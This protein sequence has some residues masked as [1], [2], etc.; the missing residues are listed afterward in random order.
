MQ[1]GP[2]MLNLSN[3]VG[4]GTNMQADW[5][6]VLQGDSIEEV[7]GHAET[8]SQELPDWIERKLAERGIKRNVVVRR[9]RLNQ[10]YAYQIMAGLRRA[11]RDKLVQLCFG[12]GLSVD[13][14]CEL[15][16]VGSVNRL[17]PTCRRDIIIAY[18]LDHGLDVTE[19]DDLLWRY[20]ESTLVSEDA[21]AHK[22]PA[23]GRDN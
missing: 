4:R 12:M 22:N 3:N 8:S 16:E 17:N 1:I 14:A 21:A 6:L 23:V 18:C 9:S 13:E 20:G 10:T 2:K 19:C 11:S 15:L 7:L 5:A